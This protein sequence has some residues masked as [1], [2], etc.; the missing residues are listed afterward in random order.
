MGSRL[1]YWRCKKGM[2]QKKLAMLSGIR[3]SRISELENGRHRV[4]SIPLRNA[5]RLARALGVHAED[6]IDDDER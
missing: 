2:S 6:L 1:R 3:Q 5:A 4:E